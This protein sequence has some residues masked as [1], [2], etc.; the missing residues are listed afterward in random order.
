MFLT[1]VRSEDLLVPE[2]KPGSVGRPRRLDALQLDA[3]HRTLGHGRALLEVLE[4]QL[5]AGRPRDLA[6]VRPRVV[7]QPSAVCDALN[8]LKKVSN[9]NFIGCLIG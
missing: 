5:S 3:G 8:H 6:A 9:W 7:G 4:H 1:S 2:A